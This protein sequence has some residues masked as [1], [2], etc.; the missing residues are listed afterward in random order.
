MTVQDDD[1]NSVL[2]VGHLVQTL[3]GSSAA[4]AVRLAIE[5]HTRGEAEVAAFP[6]QAGA[7]QLVVALQRH[8]L[9]GRIRRH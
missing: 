6:D 7:E 4:D 2:V 1:V 5:V 9:H 8:G 3:C